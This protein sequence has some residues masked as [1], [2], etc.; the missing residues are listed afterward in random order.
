VKTGDL[1]TISRRF[2][3]NIER[4]A[5]YLSAFKWYQNHR[6]WRAL[7]LRTLL[8]KLCIC[9]QGWKKPKFLWKFFL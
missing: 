3:K 2:L 1:Q 6:L 9:N 5:T 8:Y 4:Y 7:W